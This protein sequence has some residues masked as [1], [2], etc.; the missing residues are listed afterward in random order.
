MDTVGI[1][2]PDHPPLINLLEEGV[3]NHVLATTSANISGTDAPAFKDNLEI[4]A[5]YI[6]DDYGYN[7]SG[8][9]STVVSLDKTGKIQVLR[10]GKIKI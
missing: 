5:D 1:R 2:V 3:E 6:L 10:Q 9:E 4:K 7:P 8:A